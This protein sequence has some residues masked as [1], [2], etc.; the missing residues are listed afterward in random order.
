MCI[1]E[2]ASSQVVSLYYRALYQGH[3]ALGWELRIY[4]SKRVEGDYCRRFNPTEC[5]RPDSWSDRACKGFGLSI[6]YSS[7]THVSVYCST[8]LIVSPGL[9]ISKLVQRAPRQQELS[10]MPCPATKLDRENAI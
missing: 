6:L 2:A 10:V 4:D 3:T 1:C 7:Q 5:I 8:T 9:T